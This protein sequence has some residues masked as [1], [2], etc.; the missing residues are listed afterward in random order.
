MRARVRSPGGNK[1]EKGH[2]GTGARVLSFA[3]I[4]VIVAVVG[5]GILYL[6][7]EVVGLA[8]WFAYSLQVFVAVNLSFVLNDSLTWGDRRRNSSRSVLRRWLL[9][10]TGRLVS[11]ALTTALFWILTLVVPYLAA[12]FVSIGI[13]AAANYI[14][15][16]VLV[17]DSSARRGS[18][19]DRRKWILPRLESQKDVDLSVVLPV[20]GN[21]ATVVDTVQSILAQDFPGSLEVVVVV[22]AQSPDHRAILDSPIEDERL[23]FVHPEH[24]VS[25]RDANLRRGLGIQE[26]LAPIIALVDADMVY[27]KDWA[28]KGVEALERDPSISAALGMVRSVNPDSFWQGYVDNNFLGSKTPRWSEPLRITAENFGRGEAKPGVTA[29][30][31]IRRTAI[32]EFGLPRPDFVYTYDDYAFLYDVVSAGGTLV[33]VPDLF[34]RHHH[35]DDFRSL[36]SEYVSAGQGCGDFVWAYPNSFFSIKRLTQL[37][38]VGLCT[39]VL[40][41]G[42]IGDFLTSSAVIAAVL[43]VLGVWSWFKV[44][45]IRAIAYPTATIFL[46]T[47][48]CLGFVQGLLRGGPR[49][50]LDLNRLEVDSIESEGQRAE[51]EV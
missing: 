32:Q 22:D 24:S 30:M 4:G 34:G 1:V 10:A 49:V 40:I 19:V 35:R 5:A 9:F 41:V 15:N 7:V 38:L 28:T 39:V 26:S 44:G 31:F 20:K 42:L 14:F 27:P 50:T 37:L 17:F 33:C 46:G 48:F 47:A 3:A 36:A 11:V 43:T 21:D 8:L 45:A 12:H 29:N 6:G 25:G 16:D 18:R 23:V 2:W 51:A 13:V